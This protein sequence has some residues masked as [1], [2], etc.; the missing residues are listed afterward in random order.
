MR[1]IVAIEGKL[2]VNKQIVNHGAL[3]PGKDVLPVLCSGS[4]ET[5]VGKARD[6]QRND[7]TGELS[8]EIEINPGVEYIGLE[9]FD[10]F[11]Y[12]QLVE[13]EI[14]PDM[15]IIKKGIIQSISLADDGIRIWE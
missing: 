2:S 10:A 4:Y 14:H 6:F 9:K 15:V 7:E 3:E 8:Y 11:A 5:I 12:C 13:T 1:K